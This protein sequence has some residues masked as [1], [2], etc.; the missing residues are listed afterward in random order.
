MRLRGAQVTDIVV[1]VVGADDGVMPQTREA[2]NHARAA[3][4]PIIVA[5]N[6]V[7]LE[8]AQVDRVKQ[9]LT[10]LGLVP[11]EWGGDTV[12][13]EVSARKKTGI[14][15]LL[16]MIL[17]VSDLQELKTDFNRLAQGVVLESK[18]D[19]TKG[20]V[21]TV[22]LQAGVLKVGQ[23]FIAGSTYGKVRA[24][25]DDK[26]ERLHTAKAPM[27]VEVLG[28]HDVPMVADQF[29]VIVDEARARQI[30]SYRQ[31]KLRDQTLAK[32][33]RMTLEQLHQKISEE[34]VSE[35]PVILKADVQ[36]CVE[37]ISDTLQKLSTDKVRIKFIHQATGAV[38]ETDVLLASASDAV[39]IGFN[40]RPERKAQELA[41]KENVD[42]RLYTVIYNLTREVQS[43][44]L[45]LLQPTT[46]ETMLGRAEVREIF[47]VS[48][49]GNVAGCSVLEGRM[50]RDA[51]ARLLR[52]NVV[53]YDG[54]LQSLRRYKDDVPEV[55]AGVECG[56][57]LEKYQDVKPG[58]IIEAYK[59]EVVKI[60]T[61]I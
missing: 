22:L 7:D 19:R 26:G 37:V 33:A 11:E 57:A 48:K 51:S 32:P 58:D 55:R 49:I 46:K 39:I 9:Q 60:D 43:A 45:G 50:V 40:V 59:T 10:D 28:F 30:F 4:V 6:K 31:S 12:F 61:G 42:I 18:L 34:A 38:T 5:V 53:V 41:E 20:P 35:L 14:E 17:L 25:F 52:D 8:N 47:R 13:V 15:L 16:E 36:G 44:M 23:P 56:I 3:N 2:I 29:Q 27:P 1:L 54:R 24:L 21:A